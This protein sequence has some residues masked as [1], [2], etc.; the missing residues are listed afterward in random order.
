M[1]FSNGSSGQQQKGQL[2]TGWKS[3]EAKENMD[4]EVA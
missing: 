1:K 4:S 2:L 3:C